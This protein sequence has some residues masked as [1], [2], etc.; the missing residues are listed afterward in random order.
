[1]ST[2]TPAALAL[3][4]RARMTGEE[5][6]LIEMALAIADEQSICEIECNAWADLTDPHDRWWNTAPMLDE[7][8]LSDDEIAFNRRFIEYAER[9]GL[10][11]R[12]PAS[13]G[14]VRILTPGLYGR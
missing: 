2:L 4:L 9:R 14:V 10:I 12:H 3:A 7:A 11:E 8:D 1:M 13:A 6:E 5:R